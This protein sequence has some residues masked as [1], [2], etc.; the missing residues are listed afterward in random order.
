M[1]LSVGTAKSHQDDHPLHRSEFKGLS[2][3][4]TLHSPLPVNF[5]ASRRH[6]EERVEWGQGAER[7]LPPLMFFPPGVCSALGQKVTSREG[8]DLSYPPTSLGKH[9]F[10]NRKADRLGGS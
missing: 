7:S 2:E 5:Q 8:T 4:I 10:M 9:R 1:A 3:S 6:R